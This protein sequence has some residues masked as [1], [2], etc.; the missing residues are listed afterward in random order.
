MFYLICAWD[1]YYPCSGV[2]NIQFATQS[3]ELANEK[4]DELLREGSFDKVE[5]YTSADLN[6]IFDIKET[7]E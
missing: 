6:W 5:V 2:G 7:T 3:K 4:K 1:H